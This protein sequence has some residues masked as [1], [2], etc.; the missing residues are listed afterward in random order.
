MST[1]NVKSL[2]VAELKEEL[3]KRGLDTKGLKKDLA[4]RLQAALNEQS[5]AEEEK[6]QDP[7]LPTPASAAN[8][9]P[10]TPLQPPPHVEPAIEPLP[11]EAIEKDSGDGG[12]AME[13]EMVEAP[14]DSVE[15]VPL[16]VDTPLEDVG[17]KVLDT[18]IAERE[19]KEAQNIP[20]A[21]HHS[22]NGLSL[23]AEQENGD[24]KEVARETQNKYEET[25]KSLKEREQDREAKPPT[26][27]I[28][29]PAKRSI[30]SVSPSPDH[31]IK[32]SRNSP[33]PLSTK[34]VT[35]HP[36]TQVLYIQNLKRP[37]TQSS[38]HEHLY[39]NTTP[40]ADDSLLPPPKAPF[41]SSE[42]PGLWLSGVKDHAF[43][44]YSSTA[45]A[46]AA[47]ERLHGQV[48]PAET[49][50]AL[51]IEFIKPD[52]LLAL[53]QHEETAWANGRQKLVLRI[54]KRSMDGEGKGDGE[55]GDVVEFIF[56]GV[57][58]LGRAPIR[59][60]AGYAG[61]AGFGDQKFMPGRGWGRGPR[62]GLPSGPGINER[63]PPSGPAASN[64]RI[65]PQGLRGPPR[66]VPLSGT[67]A[68]GSA[69][70]MPM[71]GSGPGF[72]GR[73][74]GNANEVGPGHAARLGQ[75][76]SRRGFDQPR[77]PGGPRE[78]GGFGRREWG[79]AGDSNER[80]GKIGRPTK[81]QPTLFWN[82]G[83]GAK[84]V[85]GAGR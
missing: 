2:K 82:K 1:V 22:P 54:T 63:F 26:P 8:D 24:E 80:D 58:G 79:R 20:L 46:L 17:S 75:P 15:G 18:K 55:T 40:F 5:V 7:R 81:F 36:P 4:E 60:E 3:S 44:V 43:A 9:H 52:K 29:A 19:T 37:F 68:I 84:T 6:D 67:N 35:V 23:P 21:L 74:R 49:G 73:G 31:P 83:P 51:A 85:D 39:L 72:S 45:D 41:N 12:R 61:H 78:L 38:L 47:A 66:A 28:V 27:P 10:S 56:E 50:S 48:W 65:G 76:D 32:K 11:M 70:G 77:G 16:G 53:V 25:P 71:R 57:G 64:G 69:G 33:S 14:G 42:Y 62:A 13:E 30:S 59:G 34:L